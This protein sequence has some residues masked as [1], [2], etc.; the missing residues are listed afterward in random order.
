MTLLHYKAISIESP[1]T[2]IPRDNIL[3]YLP[4]EVLSN[5]IYLSPHKGSNDP[6]LDTLSGDLGKKAAELYIVSYSV[7]F[8]CRYKA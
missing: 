2:N 8:S 6:S 3:S 4:K 5:S 7:T 1:V